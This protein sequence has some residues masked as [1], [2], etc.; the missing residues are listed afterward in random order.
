MKK[1][2]LIC[3]TENTHIE[4]FHMSDIKFFKGEGYEVH[5]AD[6]VNGAREYCDKKHTISF[7]RSPLS[8]EN[9]KAYK[10]LHRLIKKEGYT[11]IHCHN[12]I[13]GAITRL[14]ARSFRKNGLKVLYTAHGFHFYK[15]API[16]NWLLYYPVE[17]IC[18][19][20]TD[21]LITIN[22]EDYS[23]AQNKMKAKSI[24][25][26]PGVGV[27]IKKYSQVIVDVPIK[28]KS[29]GIP[30]DAILLLSVGEINK[31]KNHEIIIRVLS[32]MSN[33]KVYYCIAG[34]GELKN[35]LTN[36]SQE[37]GIGDRV[38]FL[39]FRKDI[40]ELCSIADIFCFPSYREGLSVALMEAMRAGLPCI[41]SRIRGN[42]DLI[43]E[44]KGGYLCNPN[45]EEEFL[46]AIDDL[47]SNRQ[48]KYEMGKNNKEEIKKFDM[49]I[50]RKQFQRIYKEVING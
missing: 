4:Q 43:I 16:L 13:A 21:V 42:T 10:Q 37:L 1:K 45:S 29:I 40:H 33:K 28:R 34:V 36:L 22:K 8:I 39:G 5:I 6:N 9:I 47:I 27:D 44:K 24:Y 49:D 14:A 48:K 20:F 25:Y 18:S 3:A 50:V 11:L 31:N 38:I 12:P 26:V 35:K 32:K 17:K 19:Y 7:S 41:V 30:E 23:F 15:G 2:V 46:L